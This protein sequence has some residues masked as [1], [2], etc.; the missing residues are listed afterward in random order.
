MSVQN[1]NALD[2]CL[3]KITYVNHARVRADVFEVM[4]K[5]Q[6]LY[7]K[8]ASISMLCS[9]LLLMTPS[10]LTRKK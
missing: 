6:T 10:Y 8:I 4:T 5:L 1:I 2:E 7:P 9:T 3:K